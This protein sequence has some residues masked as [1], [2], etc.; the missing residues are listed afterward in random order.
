MTASTTYIDFA[1]AGLSSQYS[2]AYGVCNNAIIEVENGNIRYRSDGGNPT[3][4]EG[5]MVRNGQVFYLSSSDDIQNF[6][7]IRTGPD[8]AVL[9]ITFGVTV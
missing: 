9:R 4:S 1:G 5:H 2:G 7:V 6:K 3:A 8:D